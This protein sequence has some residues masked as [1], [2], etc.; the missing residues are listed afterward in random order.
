MN[1][2]K[3]PIHTAITQSHYNC[4]MLLIKN[5]VK[6]NPESINF[7]DEEG[8]TPLHWAIINRHKDLAIYLISKAKADVN[9]QDKYKLTPLSPLSQPLYPREIAEEISELLKT[10]VQVI[11]PPKSEAVVAVS[12]SD[13]AQY[14]TSN[15][16]KDIHNLIA[17]EV[18]LLLLLIYL[19]HL[20]IFIYLFNNK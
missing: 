17:D 10:P 11:E 7:G 16:V 18:L 8:R 14:I 19:S 5:M 3:V 12:D 4:G 13:I 15:N 2:K 6:H 9:I 1:K 20:N